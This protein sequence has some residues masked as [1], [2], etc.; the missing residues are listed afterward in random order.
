[1]PLFHLGNHCFLLKK[2]KRLFSEIRI[3]VLFICSFYMTQVAVFGQS[4]APPYQLGFIPASVN[5]IDVAFPL[6]KKWDL[7]G[8]T[9]VQLVTQGAYTNKNHYAYVQRFVFR[10]WL[11][12]SGFKNMKL[13]VGYAYNHKYEIKEAG[14][15]DILEQRLIIMGTY[16]QVMPKGS[17]FEQIR[18]E[19]KFFDD[20]DGIHRTIPRLRGRFGVNHFL[21][22]RANHPIFKSSNISYYTEIMFKFPSKDYASSR[23]D[24]FRESVYYSAGVTTNLN[25]LVG[26]IAQIQQST[27]G[28]KFDVYYGP[29]LALKWNFNPKQRE[30]FDSVDGGGD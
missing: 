4:A 30:T 29:T 3:V 23:F 25:F 14:N 20:K 1:M 19:T 24:I 5:E 6:V 28:T 7:S 15:P 11:V 26:I 10:P 21:R 9:D 2:N 18:F 17:M 27:S 12:Y 16:A 8:Q 13:F 22:Q